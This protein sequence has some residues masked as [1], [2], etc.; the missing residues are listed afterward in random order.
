MTVAFQDPVGTHVSFL[1]SFNRTLC[2]TL[3]NDSRRSS[4]IIGY[5]SDPRIWMWISSHFSLV[6]MPC[7][8]ASTRSYGSAQQTFCLVNRAPDLTNVCPSTVV[9]VPIYRWC[10]WIRGSVCSGV[11]GMWT[12]CVL[13][14]VPI[15]RLVLC[16]HKTCMTEKFKHEKYE[17]DHLTV[18][19]KTTALSKV[20]SRSVGIKH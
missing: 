7:L 12:S 11:I 10:W 17:S 18:C 5:F 15:T 2:K 20:E 6:N 13:W 19:S 8:E 9:H 1:R 16:Y 14:C 3:S 4:T